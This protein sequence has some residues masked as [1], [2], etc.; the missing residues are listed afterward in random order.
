MNA[1]LLLFLA[2]NMLAGGGLEGSSAV[3]LPSLISGSLN[4]PSS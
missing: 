1:N 2:A 4:I 3:T